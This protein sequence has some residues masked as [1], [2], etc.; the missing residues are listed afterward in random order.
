VKFLASYN[1]N[2]ESQWKDSLMLLLILML[3]PLY[4]FFWVVYQLRRQYSLR[5]RGYWV[6]RKGRDSIEYQERLADKVERIIIDGEMMAVGP[7][8]VYVPTDEEWKKM[9]EWAQGRR[10]EIIGRVK[11][12]L[13][14]KNYEYDES[15]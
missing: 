13:G 15:S 5:F 11:D 12:F 6:T 1:V 14:S 4:P 8:V 7:H 10:D 3:L 2:S 9:P